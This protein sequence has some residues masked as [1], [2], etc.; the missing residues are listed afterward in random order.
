MTFRYSA[1]EI[2]KSGDTV[3]HVDT[4]LQTT[5]RLLRVIE[6]STRLESLLLLR[7]QTSSSFSS[8]QH[9]DGSEVGQNCLTSVSLV[10]LACHY[11][12][13]S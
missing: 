6:L 7:V 13:L 2:S 3:G 11:L 9:Y 5:V 1:T 4:S 10:S 8:N 12:L